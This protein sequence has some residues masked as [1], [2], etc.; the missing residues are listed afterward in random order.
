M[1][2]TLQILFHLRLKIPVNSFIQGYF[3]FPSPIYLIL[4]MVTS[5]VA[6]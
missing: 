6:T 5:E 2:L 1:V 4:I 3:Q